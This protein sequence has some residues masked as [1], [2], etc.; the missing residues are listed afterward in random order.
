[1]A[2]DYLSNDEDEMTTTKR[3]VGGGKKI[4]ERSQINYRVVRIK[5]QC[6]KYGV[7]ISSQT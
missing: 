1:M 3:K 7:E 6:E 5:Y 2:D 4:K